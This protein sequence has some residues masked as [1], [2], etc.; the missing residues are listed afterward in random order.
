MWSKI[1][2]VY[3]LGGCI[4]GSEDTSSILRFNYESVNKTWIHHGNMVKKRYDHAIGVVRSRHVLPWCQGENGPIDY[5]NPS[6]RFLAP[7]QMYEPSYMPF[8][9]G[10]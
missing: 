1:V 9:R 8:N 6:A 7:Y 3:I 5:V 10:N 2:I 4:D